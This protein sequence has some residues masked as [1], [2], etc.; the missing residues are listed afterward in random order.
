MS[1]DALET[2]AGALA[3]GTAVD[4]SAAESAANG[5]GERSLLDELKAVSAIVRPQR[6]RA[7][8]IA[9]LPPV[10]TSIAYDMVVVIA[11]IKTALAVAGG[12]QMLVHALRP[13]GAVVPFLAI[14]IVFGASAAT[15]FV[16]GTRDARAHRL[17]MFFLLIASTFSDRLL[18][19]L[20]GEVWLPIVTV[21]RRLPVDAFLAF[22]LWQFVYAFPAPPFRDID[23]RLTQFFLTLSLVLAI[24]LFAV[25]ATL[26][27]ERSA[28]SFASAFAIAAK[29]KRAVAGTYYWPLI[30]LTV[31][32]ALPYLLWK[33]RF[34]AR[35][36]RR[37]TMLLAT[38]IVGGLTPMT[39]AVV[40]S[41]FFRYFD[42][43][44]NR[45]TVGFILY[46]ALMVIVPLTTHAVLVQRAIDIQ[47]IV[48]KMMQRWLVRRL[49]RVLASAP[50]GYLAAHVYAN[51]TRPIGDIIATSQPV[52]LTALPL[53]GVL[54]LVFHSQLMQAIDRWF[55]AAPPD[56]PEVLARLQQ[57]LRE[58]QGVR[59][60]VAV[61]E[62]EIERA[63]HPRTI[64]VLLMDETG[65]SLMSPVGSIPALRAD[66][67]LGDLL[68]LAR[69][70]I[71]VGLTA[72]VG[73]L[74]SDDDRRWLAA[75]EAQVIVRLGRTNGEL[76]GAIAIGEKRSEMPLSSHD[77]ALLAMMAGQAAL[78]IENRSLLDVSYCY[79]A[80][81]AVRPGLIDWNE[82]PGALCPTCQ[83]MWDARAATCVCGAA[84][85]PAALPLVVRGK[86]R[87]ERL[88]GAG[89]MGVVYK[90][91]DLGL[92]RKVAIKTLPRLR[93]DRAR[94]LQR[95]ARVAAAVF[96]PNLATIFG[97][98][99]WR[100]A[101]LLIEEYL[102]GG[103]L[104]DR[105]QR[106][107]LTLAETIALGIVLADALDRVHAA[108]ILH[109]DIKPTNIGYTR[110]G[111]PKLLDFGVAR[112]FNETWPLLE[113]AER[114]LA[115]DTAAGPS[116][117]TP[118]TAFITGDAL[119]GTALY[120]CPEA[121]TGT[122]PGPGFDVWSLTLVL[123]EAYGGEHPLAGVSVDAA[124]HRIRNA[125]MPNIR[126]YRPDCPAAMAAFFAGSLSR[127]VS[128]RPADVAEMRNRLHRL[129]A[130]LVPASD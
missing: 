80:A 66:S 33:S 40:I 35:D 11:T 81:P 130:E 84:T 88:I 65:Q 128:L 74:F 2:V 23:R 107:R 8:T 18:L 36:A 64:A 45:Q 60:V 54:L 70:D 69:A 43:P 53:V 39:V 103:T 63:I 75:Q 10:P 90:A 85:V 41:P 112:V 105:L 109:G 17:G 76:L 94:R 48:T 6:A 13:P 62:R 3:D 12:W 73:R 121:L 96:H 92:N 125:P 16:G 30:L 110:D 97:V 46:G 122:E 68:R 14:L 111:T 19:G 15:L 114:A 116:G 26:L 100:G 123:F 118:M 57:G 124:L 106:E 120:I 126:R 108:G 87:V 95:E 52:V 82:E 37:R 78:V 93:A 1:D 113:Q 89:G 98:E 9:P 32:P 7:E 42:D 56:Y 22:A 27:F 86:F 47:L 67:M 28:P 29:F 24:G 115:G 25:N 99:T 119:A 20:S 58:A 55:L 77:R 79:L 71:C 31:V 117:N 5:A 104:A 61:L 59:D 34:E 127:D 50:L 129:R 38:S 83:T 102:D 91:V 44:A 101:P 4:W 21:L 51:R 72:P 49:V